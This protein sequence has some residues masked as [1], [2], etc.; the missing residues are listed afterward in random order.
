MENCVGGKAVATKIGSPPVSPPP[1]APFFRPDERSSKT[2]KRAII[3]RREARSRL[4]APAGLTPPDPLRGFVNLF[5][6]FEI[7]AP[8]A[9]RQIVGRPDG[10]LLHRPAASGTAARRNVAILPVTENAGGNPDHHPVAPVFLSLRPIPEIHEVDA[11]EGQLL[12][13][14]LAFFHLFETEHHLVFSLF[15][16]KKC[17]APQKMGFLKR[18]GFAFAAVAGPVSLMCLQWSGAR[19][20]GTSLI[21][22]NS[23]APH[24]RGPAFSGFPARSD[25][26][27]SLCTR[28]FSFQLAW[29]PNRSLGAPG[30]T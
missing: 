3:W 5:Q 22:C 7:V 24:L 20:C 1:A 4:I 26:A 12:N 30:E 14:D 21:F 19:K 18:C 6:T 27:S 16:Q 8:N 17:G 11:E 13:R 15:R 23:V 28:T 2:M 25:E 29:N 10:R 9:W